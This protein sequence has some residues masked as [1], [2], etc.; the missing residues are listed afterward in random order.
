MYGFPILSKSKQTTYKL[1]LNSDIGPG[2]CDGI[3]TDG[4]GVFLVIPARREIRYWPDFSSQEYK[5]WGSPVPTTDSASGSLNFNDHCRCLIF[6]GA[7][8]TAYN[9][10]LQQGRWLN[11]TYKLGS[12]HSIASDS[13]R[14]LFASGKSVLLYST[15]NNR[16]ENAP[17]SLKSLPGGLISGVAIDSSGSAW[18]AD[19][20]KGI[21][22]G[23]LSLN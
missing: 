18:I 4:V 2:G 9:L 10:S 11:V 7:S 16:R 23:P 14:I 21:I 20:D 19:F 3:A 22:K 13:N 12:V 8:G 1:L 15:I 17:P 5:S 6:A